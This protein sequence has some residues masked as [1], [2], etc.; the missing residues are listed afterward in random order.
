M[1]RITKRSNRRKGK[2]V[3]RKSKGVGC[4]HTP[5]KVSTKV[6]KKR[7]T[8]KRKTVRGKRMCKRKTLYGGGG[9]EVTKMMNSEKYPNN[10]LFKMTF[11]W[12]QKNTGDGGR[13]KAKNIVDSVC[14]DNNTLYFLELYA[15]IIYPLMINY[16]INDLNYKK[17]RGEI[18]KTSDDKHKLCDGIRN[19]LE[20]SI[21][22]IDDDKLNDFYK[23]IMIESDLKTH[24]LQSLNSQYT[25]SKSKAKLTKEDALEKILSENGVKGGKYE[26]FQPYQGGNYDDEKQVS[27]IFFIDHTVLK[28]EL[29]QPNNKKNTVKTLNMALIDDNKLKGIKDTSKFRPYNDIKDLT[30]RYTKIIEYLWLG[31]I[32][33]LNGT[34]SSSQ[35]FNRKSQMVLNNKNKE[36]GNYVFGPITGLGEKKDKAIKDTHPLTNDNI[37]LFKARMKKLFLLPVIKNDNETIDYVL[38]MLNKQGTQETPEDFYKSILK[39]SSNYSE[40][41]KDVESKIDELNNDKDKVP[42]KIYSEIVSAFGMQATSGFMLSS[43]ADAK[44]VNVKS[45]REKVLAK[46]EDI[47]ILS[48]CG[49][50]GTSNN[51]DD[52]REIM[53]YNENSKKIY[54]V[55]HGGV[56]NGKNKL[57]DKTGILLNGEVK[58]VTV[59]NAIWYSLKE[60]V[61]AGENNINNNKIIEIFTKCKEAE[62]EVEAEVEEEARK[63]KGYDKILETSAFFELSNGIKIFNF[64]CDSTAAASHIGVFKDIMD[65]LIEQGIDIIAGDTNITTN[66][67]NGTTDI[68]TILD[69]LNIAK[70]E[71]ITA[72]KM[73]PKVLVH[74][75]RIK[76]DMF[77][78]NQVHKGEDGWLDDGETVL[79]PKAVEL[80]G[81]MLLIKKSQETPNTNSANMPIV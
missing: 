2:A 30:R 36:L 69:D 25:I 14:F 17:T 80:D 70:Y 52:Y 24:V 1:V 8:G 22:G 6:N 5:R 63:A 73:N 71:V 60:V 59:K 29:S 26:I 9:D 49:F 77:H 50:G 33:N 35:E 39:E 19:I 44:D 46:D 75:F 4:K 40:L 18:K 37:N 10:P 81:Q 43:D 68:D 23:K 74:K 76:E 48:E 16:E 65:I 56:E 72:K 47:V 45:L 55:N 66:K 57:S 28:G 54:Y 38:E 20:T 53:E 12:I 31:C 42:H 15:Y 32:G 34:D 58:D 7:L 79:N 64:H 41:K 27:D 62:A 13:G 21:E 61:N 67:S 3:Y 11:A 78:N 51:A